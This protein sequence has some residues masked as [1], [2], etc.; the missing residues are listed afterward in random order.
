MGLGYACEWSVPV[1][2]VSVVE[3]MDRVWA[4]VCAYVP[5]WKACFC[6][7]IPQICAF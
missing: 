2:F 7:Y 1:G 6:S 4:S 3:G 5:V